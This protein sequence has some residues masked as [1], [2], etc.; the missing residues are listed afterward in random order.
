[1][2]TKIT[3]FRRS[4]LLGPYKCG[5]AGNR[6]PATLLGCPH[7]KGLPP[8]QRADLDARLAARRAAFDPLH[9]KG[10]RPHVISKHFSKA[11]FGD[12]AA[13]YAMLYGFFHN[14]LLVLAYRRQGDQGMTRGA[15]VAS[16]VVLTIMSVAM[17][18]LVAAAKPL[19]GLAKIPDGHFE[20]YIGEMDHLLGVFLTTHAQSA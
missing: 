6:F 2:I 16:E 14:D 4:H 11:G 18:T 20:Q 12:L 13:P 1:M 7:G 15:P 9:A 5:G 10:L 3:R 8:D 17:V 19:E